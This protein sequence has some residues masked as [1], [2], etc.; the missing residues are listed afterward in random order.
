MR[1]VRLVAVAILLALATACGH[2]AARPAAGQERTPPPP[3]S[4]WTTSTPKSKG[5]PRGYVQYQDY[6]AACHGAGAGKPGTL[7]LQAKYKGGKPA[8]LAERTDLTPQLIRLC[9]RHGIGFMPFARKTEISDA[10]LDAIV[11][12]LTRNNSHEKHQAH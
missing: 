7:T 9:V 12:Y 8:M 6:C 3:K 10:D 5:E 11:A 4:A 2:A 1:K